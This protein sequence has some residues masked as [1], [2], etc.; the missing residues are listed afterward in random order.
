M[1]SLIRL[2]T[3]AVSAAGALFVFLALLPT[4][5]TAVAV[6][7][8]HRCIGASGEPSFSDQSCTAGS[9]PTTTR[10]HGMRVASVRNVGLPLNLSDCARSREE[11][12]QR[13]DAALVTHDAVRLSGLILWQSTSPRA[14]RQS[15]LSLAR[16]ARQPA[17]LVV[18][19]AAFE[20]DNGG[21]DAATL[22][23][24]RSASTTDGNT[25]VYEFRYTL[26]QRRGCYWLKP[27]ES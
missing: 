24:L 14:A 21:L 23:S 1:S 17:D 4:P 11:L 6:Q 20:E 8:V 9:A 13:A 18:Q 10:V 2:R 5:A 7:Y 19:P 22:V 3:V 12:Q 15:L 26:A 25:P 16:L 27:V